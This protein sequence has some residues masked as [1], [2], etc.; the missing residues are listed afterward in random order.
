MKILFGI[1]NNL[2]EAKDISQQLFA[3]L[4]SG[5]VKDARIWTQ[6]LYNTIE[7]NSSVFMSEENWFSF[8][9]AIREKK[10]DFQADYILT[11]EQII[12]LSENCDLLPD[13]LKELVSDAIERK[14]HILELP[15]DEDADYE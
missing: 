1:I 8:L 7:Q 11:G 14:A 5:N 13:D 3:A 6:K 2:P 10:Q 15:I 9:H 12:F 4:T